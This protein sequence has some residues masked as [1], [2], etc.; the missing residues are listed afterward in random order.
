MVK[1]MMTPSSLFQRH[2]K[3]Q[4]KLEYVEDPTY[5]VSINSH[6]CITCSKF[7][8]SSMASYPSILICNCHQKLIF[9]GQHLTHS[10]EL[11]QKKANFGINKKL[12]HIFQ[13][14]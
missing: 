10:C 14:A 1:K 2:N 5:S 12:N 7:D 13:A 6:V 4:K 3:L 11:Y 8:Y 9:Q